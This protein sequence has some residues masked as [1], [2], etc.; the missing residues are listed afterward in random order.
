MIKSKYIVFDCETGGLYPKENPITQFA[1]VILDYETLKEVDRY[2]TFI[3]PYNELVITQEALDKTMV[4]MSDIKKGISVE[5][6]VSTLD[7]FLRGHNT[8]KKRPEMGRLVPVGQNIPFDNRFLTYA[9]KLCGKKWLECVYDNFIDTYPLAKLTWGLTGEEKLTLGINC[10][11]AK[12]KLTDAHG[13]MNDVLATAELLRYF[14]KKLRSK[15][16][17]VVAETSEGRKTGN[18][19]YEFKCVN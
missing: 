10:E 2:E 19:F 7:K 8:S 16:G 13:A 17:D 4:S 5:E 12:I 18:D 1:C 15:K 14:K 3:K 11:R 6:F 9:F